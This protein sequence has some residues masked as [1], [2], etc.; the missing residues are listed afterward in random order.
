[1]NRFFKRM[2]IRIF[3]KKINMRTAGFTVLLLTLAVLLSNCGGDAAK[4]EAKAQVCTYSYDNSKSVLEWTAFKFTERKGVTGTFNEI[5]VT[6]IA[7]ADDPKKMVESLEF[8]IN[9]STAETQ[10][11]ERNGK[12][13]KLFFGSMSSDKITGRVKSLGS[14]GIASI[15]LN[16]NNI[17]KIVNGSYTLIDG[18]FSFKAK[19]DV[20]NWNAGSGINALNEACKEL[21]TGAD[22][23]SKLWS[24]VELSFTTELVATCN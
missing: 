7:S 21:H 17:E 20:L 2:L 19:I 23:V 22:G 14:K 12:I 3:E 10:N 5:E 9:T 15:I 11:E 8:S 1:M 13:V 24:E 6:G 16:M 18:I 4:K